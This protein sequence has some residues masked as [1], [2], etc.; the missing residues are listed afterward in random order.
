MTKS[1][2]HLTLWSGSQKKNFGEGG[3]SPRRVDGVPCKNDIYCR[4]GGVRQSLARY[5][6]QF[7][8][9]SQNNFECRTSSNPHIEG[10]EVYMAAIVEKQVCNKNSLASCCTTFVKSSH[11]LTKLRIGGDFEGIEIL[12]TRGGS[13][14]IIQNNFRRKELLWEYGH[15]CFKLVY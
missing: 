10:I 1:A 15:D 12:T 11:G 5:S 9:G 8:H 7:G 4:E 2:R 3:L 14:L 13:T 6:A